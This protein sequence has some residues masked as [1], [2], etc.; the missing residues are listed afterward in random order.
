MLLITTQRYL[1]KKLHPAMAM[2]I[3]VEGVSVSPDHPK[4]GGE[5]GPPPPTGSSVNEEGPSK[6]KEPKGN[7]ALDSKGKGKLDESEEEEEEEESEAD[8]LKRKRRDE[9]L[10]ENIRIAKNTEVKERAE[11]EAQE[12]LKNSISLMDYGANK[13]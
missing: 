11:R 1:D 8:K 2:R 7:V 10:N 9:E 5:I 13:K 6:P 3:R 4:Q 12:M